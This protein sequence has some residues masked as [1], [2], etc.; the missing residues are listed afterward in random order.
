MT[1]ALG[2]DASRLLPVDVVDIDRVI[3]ALVGGDFKAERAGRD[4]FEAENR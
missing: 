4:V 2:A 1:T 3:D